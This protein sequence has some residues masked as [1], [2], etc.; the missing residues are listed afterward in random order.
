[1]KEK[2]NLNTLLQEITK[3]DIQKDLKAY[4]LIPNAGCS[5]CISSAEQFMFDNVD[6]LQNIQFILTGITSKKLYKNR[7]GVLLQNSKILSDYKN[8]AGSLDLHTIYPKIFHL[9]N[10]QISHIAEASHGAKGD[11]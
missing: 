3:K 7:F 11:V 6:K 10:G 1:M 5:G 4:I 9:K 8:I 2:Q